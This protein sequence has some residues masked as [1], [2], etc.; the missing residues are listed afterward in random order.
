MGENNMRYNLIEKETDKVVF[1]HNSFN[2]CI[3]QA[4]YYY[5]HCGRTCHYYIVDVENRITF[6]VNSYAIKYD[7]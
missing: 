4:K 1:S 2:A 3:G 7:R 5:R 6:D